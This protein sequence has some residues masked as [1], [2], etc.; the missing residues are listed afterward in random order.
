L[1]KIKITALLLVLIVT[2]GALPAFAG[3]V[4]L[5]VNGDQANIFD[6]IKKDGTSMISATA[7]ARLSGADAEKTGENTI[8]ITEQS[9]TLEL[10]AGE[11]RGKLD[12][13]HVQLPCTPL[14]SGTKFFIPL[15][16]TAA[17]FGYDVSWNQ[18]R[19][20]VILT[21]DEKRDGMTPA[22]LLVKSN[23]VL[24]DINTYTMEGTLDINM[25]FALDGKAMKNA[26]QNLAIEISG[27]V[28]NNPMEMY[29]KQKMS[30]LPKGGPKE[31][32]IET[33]TTGSKMYLKTQ[34]LGWVEQETAFPAGFWEEQQ[35]I[36]SDP[37]KAV[38]QMKEMGVLLNFGND[39]TIEGRD[40]YV[41]NGS[42]DTEKFQ[43]GYQE[44]MQKL[45]QAFQQQENT[46]V[47][48][49]KI[50]EFI[51]QLFNNMQLDYYY[52]VYI[53]KDSLLTDIVEYDVNVN[54]T[55]SPGDIM[56]QTQQKPGAPGEIII[57]YDMKGKFNIKDPD[58]PFKAPDVSNAKKMEDLRRLK[59]DSGQSGEQ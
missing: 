35:D 5:Q 27:Q 30:P 53:N 28:L 45:L 8:K 7:F 16:F 46:E 58:K 38:K 43:Q 21:R 49:A 23:Q 20:T 6:V 41:V 18:T 31:I 50:Q 14:K 11:L 3:D 52:T 54:C 12:N 15:R 4:K 17:A 24:Q 40:Y 32:T 48:S 2:M 9:K 57:S 10:T 26:P 55:L 22:D 1:Q 47:D 39:V 56:E 44:M 25:N 29:I 19:E 33:Y 34:E 37:V 51:Q 42:L 36:Q 59:Q 13:E